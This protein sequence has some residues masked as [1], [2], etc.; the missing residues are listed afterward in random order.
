MTLRLA[1]KLGGGLHLSSTPAACA[2]LPSSRR[3][4]S[5]RPITD[6]ISS[7]SQSPW[8]AA[9]AA[10]TLDGRGGHTLHEHRADELHRGG[11]ACP[12]ETTWTGIPSGPH[13]G[14]RPGGGPEA[15]AGVPIPFAG[16][17]PSRATSAKRSPTSPASSRLRVGARVQI[18]VD[19][20]AREGWK[21]TRA[22]PS[23]TAAAFTLSTTSAPA[24]VSASGALSGTAG[25]SHGP[26]LRP[27]QVGSQPAAGLAEAEDR[28]D[29]QICSSAGGEHP[30][31]VR[32]VLGT[33]GDVAGR[34]GASAACAAASAGPHRR[35]RPL[36]G[37][38]GSAS[39]PSRRARRHVAVQAQRRRATVAQSLRRLTCLR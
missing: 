10:A 34:L 21:S 22:A 18:A 13:L 20:L 32:P 3:S 28:E 29:R 16:T 24:T 7:F 2:R 17:G 15:S 11:V 25:R 38:R 1:E 12:V 36:H 26:R 9:S 27:H 5:G 39:A 37:G 35:R 31:E 8:P 33:A 6:A 14:E 4:R 19:G 23:A 30:G